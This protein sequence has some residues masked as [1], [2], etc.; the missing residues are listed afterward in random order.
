MTPGEDSPQG[1]VCGPDHPE[2]TSAV[3]YVSTELKTTQCE[4]K[5]SSIQLTFC[6]VFFSLLTVTGAGLVGI[7]QDVE[8]TNVYRWGSQCWLEWNR[9]RNVK[10]R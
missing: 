6:F 10:L 2:A 9:V 5:K 8:R 7:G 3:L 1:V 4:T